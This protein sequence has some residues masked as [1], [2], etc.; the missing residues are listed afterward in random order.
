MM[1]AQIIINKLLVCGNDFFFFFCIIRHDKTC[2]PVILTLFGISEISLARW[3]PLTK[4]FQNLNNSFLR[5]IFKLTPS[6]PILLA[7]HY[8]LKTAK[9]RLYQLTYFLQSLPHT[10]LTGPYILFEKL[11]GQIRYT[12]C[13]NTFVLFVSLQTFSKLILLVINFNSHQA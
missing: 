4:F 3:A 2:P 5:G 6:L 12:F 13:I 1:V 8:V 7:F 9:D 11:Q 10:D